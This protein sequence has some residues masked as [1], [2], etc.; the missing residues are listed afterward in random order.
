MV[1]FWLFPLAS[2]KCASLGKCFTLPVT[3]NTVLDKC[4]AFTLTAKSIPHFFFFRF[5]GEQN[6]FKYTNALLVRGKTKLLKLR[7][8]TIFVSEY[9]TSVF[10]IHMMSPGILCS[11]K[12]SKDPIDWLFYLQ[13]RPIKVVFISTISTWDQG[14]GRVRHGGSYLRRCI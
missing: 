7:N 13:H 5:W 14:K 11:I 6:T 10:P 2:F 3:I 1:A 12:Q 4:S 9:N 8:P